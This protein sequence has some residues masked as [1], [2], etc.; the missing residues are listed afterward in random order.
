MTTLAPLPRI[1]TLHLFPGE[2]AALLDVLA[3]LSPAEWDLP[4]ACAGWSMKD[5]AAHLLGDDIGRLSWGRDGYVNPAFAAGLD[6]ATLPG[7]VTAIDRQN[8]V[9]AAG[10]RRMS[11]RVIVDL[12]AL[13]GEWTQAYFASLDLDAPGMPVDWAGPEP[14]PVWFDVAREYTERWHHQQHIRDAAGRPGLKEREW[15]APVL[16]TFV[17]GLARPLAA[18]DAPAGTALR[19][20][21]TG[22]AGGEWVALRDETGWR[23][24][25]A[26]ALT[27][28]A[29]VTL[30]QETA[31]RLLTKGI[32]RNEARQQATIVGDPRLAERVLDTVSIL[33]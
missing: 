26:S 14:A 2:R 6:I 23:L 3:D 10:A 32:A 19:L 15:F 18:V 21:I 28:T 9:W 17:R 33:G 12:L 1:D 11:P 16:E 22:D 8:A 30:D 31:W 29:S 5:V 20:T 25:H 27:A 4:T 24:G 7:L 13:T